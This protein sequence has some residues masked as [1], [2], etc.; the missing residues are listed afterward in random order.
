[1]N[2]IG[3]VRVE[4]FKHD[5][6]EELWLPVEAVLLQSTTKIKNHKQRCSRQPR[7]HE[8]E[9][10]VAPLT[11]WDYVIGTADAMLTMVTHAT[12]RKG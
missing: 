5:L 8:G 3:L 9:R 1:M 10:S 6:L 4:L 2:T 12:A 7:K 11:L